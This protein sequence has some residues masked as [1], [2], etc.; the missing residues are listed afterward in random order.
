[1][2]ETPR[3]IQVG[4]MHLTLVDPHRGHERRYNRWYEE[5][6]FFSA[7]MLGPGLL[8]GARFIARRHEKARRR[9]Q[10]PFGPDAGS[11]LAVF[12]HQGDGSAYREWAPD[13][14]TRLK[15][16]NRMYAERDLVFHL[17]GA[18][19]L[20]AHRPDVDVPVQLALEHRYPYLGLSLIEL[21]N[22]GGSSSLDGYDA[23]AMTAA[24]S[25]IAMVMGFVL[26]APGGDPMGNSK[27]PGGEGTDPPYGAVLWFFDRDP[28]EEWS[29]LL[30]RQASV[31]A[32]GVGRVVWASSFVRTVVGTDTFIDDLWPV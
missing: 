15:A 24:G 23:A 17:R 6:H 13:E 28:E 20:S 26:E 1:M 22:K 5:D 21:S 19:A 11:L 7:V 30:D 18:F 4:A 10:A 9:V 16:E 25:P 12:F 31:A 3:S 32:R 2:G 14:V 29:A 27:W 8:S